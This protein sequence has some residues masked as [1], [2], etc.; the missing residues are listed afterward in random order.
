MADGIRFRLLGGFEAWSGDR[1]IPAGSWRLRKA[2]TLVKLL[3]LEPGHTLHAER[4][5][6]L[7]WPDRDVAAARNNLHQVVHAVRR[8]LSSPG[9][10]AGAVLAFRDD[11]LTLGR[12]VEVV[13]DVGELQLAVRTAT[14]AGDGDRVAALLH[15][16][17]AELLPEDAYESW[18]QPHS[19][20][21]REWRTQAV[22]RLVEAQ[23]ANGEPH[24]AVV[25]LSPV[26]ASDPLNEPATR[27]LMSA[28]VASGRRSDAL[29]VY[30]QLKQR[31]SD[32][33]GADPEP[34]TRAV[35][36]E[37]L[38][39]AGDGSPGY[40]TSVI[41]SQ[42]PGGNLP[43]PVSPLVGRARELDETEQMLARTRLL[44]LT[45]MGGVGKT[46]LGLQL[47][48]SRAADYRD[49]VYLVELAGLRDGDQVAAQIAQT[50][51]LALPSDTSA[52]DAIV[53]QLRGR[54]L[55]VVLDNCEHLLEACANVA[56]ALLRGCPG[57]RILATSREPLRIDGEVS[58]RTPS[59]ALPDA[60]CVN[61][62]V[63]LGR[64]G[65]VDLFV[66]RA[67][68]AFP[69]FALTDDNARAIFEICHRLDGIPLAIELAAACIPV[70]APQQIALRLGD[71][72]ALLRRG[73]RSAI[74]RQQTL[75]ATLMWSH[76][77]L[78]S[79]EQ[80]LF[81]RL[82]V[83]AGS[84]TMQAVE[85]VCG[86]TSPAPD[87]LSCL[88]RLV[89]TSLV[90]VD[91]RG[92]ATRYRLLDT[93]RQFAAQRLRVSGEL[94]STERRHGEWY[95][96]FAVARDPESSAS[97][98][99]MPASLDVD[100]DNLRAALTWSLEH[101]PPLAMEMAVAL[102]R[103]WLARGFLAEGQRWLEAA[104]SADAEPSVLRARAL[105]GL[106]VF[107]VRRGKDVRLRELGAAAVTIHRSIGD[108]ALL[109]MTLLA[110]AILAYMVGDWDDCWQRTLESLDTASVSGTTEATLGARHVQAFLLAERGLHQDARA[111]FDDLLMMLSRADG[112]HGP[113]LRA[114]SQ[115]FM[116][117]SVA[118]GDARLYFEET[119]LHGRVLD[120]QQA[121]AHVLC[122]LADIA[123]SCGE[124]DEALRCLNG[125][126]A[127]Y[128][129]VGDV[130]GEAAA[131]SRRACLHRI[132]EEYPDARAALTRSLAMRRLM[133]ER[134][135]ITLAMSNL[136][137]LM[138]AEGDVDG[139][140][141]MLEEQIANAGAIRDIAGQDGLTLTLA[142]IEADVGDDDAADAHLRA[143]DVPARTLP[144]V[145]RAAAWALTMHAGILARLG[146]AEESSQALATARQRFEAMRAVDGTAAVKPLQSLR[147]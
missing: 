67:S 49:G 105:L 100:H 36:R 53:G 68:A 60:E 69:A 109:A 65:S 98:T 10:D 129:E 125:A 140:R 59:L 26:V 72:M 9:L 147:S 79:E 12:D 71:A 25:L 135:A 56:A 94:A 3:A 139:G 28:L 84:F 78:S 113:F 112:V 24:G 8:A 22:M 131:L 33:L 66:R 31:L 80:T 88:A 142:S 37:L 4:V 95:R 54:Q 58:W 136:G 27:A 29:L 127:L 126:E 85:W 97:T 64:I 19:I 128:A 93:V 40:T 39:A 57:L 116:A 122:N 35:F 115:G 145:S 130:D 51:Q 83:F 5:G 2:K 114:L 101:E 32:E 111:A 81:R 55:L 42:Q 137:L 133:G 91:V 90:V 21:Y 141:R 108:E 92:D 89:D 86:G 41:P 106:A 82:S 34:Q 45:G 103:Y 16:A 77:L 70:L 99:T 23:I 63:E 96:D 104:L 6:D 73:D 75:E 20:A 62:R 124:L 11:V 47:A 120:A 61:D 74:T 132:R 110:D 43:A 14:A 50:L 102:W 144:G 123:R 44:A 146:R 119:V 15:D 134:R 48:R 107:D 52:V 118:P 30:E 17:P 143:V 138:V 121:Q 1:Q 87:V 117:R 76:D 46:A 18:L 13:T 7:L 38:T